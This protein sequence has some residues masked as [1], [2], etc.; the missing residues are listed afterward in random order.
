MK[1][2]L[3]RVIRRPR[4]DDG[5]DFGHLTA[6]LEI[7][8]NPGNAAVVVSS[9]ADGDRTTATVHAAEL[10][11]SRYAVVDGRAL[12]EPIAAAVGV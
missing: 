10:E 5:C 6:R 4:E 11:G 1:F 8:A 7:Q 9:G 12:W 3:P 2:I